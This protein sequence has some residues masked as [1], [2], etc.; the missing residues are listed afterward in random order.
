MDATLG[1][2]TCSNLHKYST[3][4]FHN[5]YKLMHNNVDT[6]VEKNYK[7]LSFVLIFTLIYHFIS[8]S[9]NQ[10]W[11]VGQKK[12]IDISWVGEKMSWTVNG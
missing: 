10:I 9:C 12:L 6:F 11:W 7:L 2:G 8:I 5:V 3:N 1:F 4:M